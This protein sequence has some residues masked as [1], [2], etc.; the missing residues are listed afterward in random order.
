MSRYR[1]VPVSTTTS[2]RSGCAAAHAAMLDAER[3]ACSAISRSQGA[4]SQ[5]CAMPMRQCFR[6]IRA[7]RDA[8]CQLPLLASARAGLTI[9]TEGRVG[10]ENVLD[11]EAPSVESAR[12]RSAGKDLLSLALIDARNHTLRGIGAGE[13][14]RGGGALG[15]PLRAEITPPLWELGHVGWFQEYWIARNVQ[16]HRG[17]RCDPTRPKLGSTLP[18]A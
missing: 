16:R 14:A 8:V 7:Q 18:D 5:C 15:A 3:R 10:E 6:S 13:P 17:E 9:R 4:P 2:G 12:M 11:I 1:S